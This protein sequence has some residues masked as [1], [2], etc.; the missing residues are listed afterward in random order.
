MTRTLSRL[1]YRFSLISSS[2]LI[3]EKGATKVFLVDGIMGKLALVLWRRTN[4]VETR[5]NKLF[6]YFGRNGYDVC[7]EGYASLASAP[8][9]GAQYHRSLKSF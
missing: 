2:Y 7:S 3:E 1:H 5:A 8:L 6:L 4:K 9:L